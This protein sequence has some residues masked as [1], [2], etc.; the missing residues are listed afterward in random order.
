VDPQWTLSGP[1]VDPWWTLGR[2]NVAAVAKCWFL[3]IMTAA[4]DS[5][6]PLIQVTEEPVTE[7]V[8]EKK[9]HSESENVLQMIIDQQKSKRKKFIFRDKQ[10]GQTSEDK[11]MGRSDSSDCDY[12][13][14]STASANVGG[15]GDQN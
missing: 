6:I 2:R 11:G 13:S 5:G 14:S 1:S 8:C 10:D 9:D 15:T 3:L 4:T 7:K 12:S